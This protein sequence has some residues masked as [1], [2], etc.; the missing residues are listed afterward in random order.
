MNLV[1]LAMNMF[2]TEFEIETKWSKKGVLRSIKSYIGTSS[3]GDTLNPM[4]SKDYFGSVDDSGFHM[5]EIMG[6]REYNK[7]IITGSV[8]ETATGSKVYVRVMM[9]NF[10]MLVIGGALLFLIA[11]LYQIIE[12]WITIGVLDYDSIIFI[13]LAIIG[14]IGYIF[15]M[16]YKIKNIR[17]NLRMIVQGADYNENY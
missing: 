13:L 5:K 2:T 15:Y 6:G 12:G 8:D 16:K 4:A 9:S 17:N 10:Q 1:W 14:G 11:F 3:S 7:H